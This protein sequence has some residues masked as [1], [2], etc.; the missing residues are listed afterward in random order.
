MYRYLLCFVLLVIQLETR[1]GKISGEVRSRQGDILPYS[2]LSVK[3]GTLSTSSNNQGQYFLELPA[4]TYTLVCRHVGYERLEKTVTVGAE[5]V[6]LDFILTPQTVSLQEVVVRPGDEDPAYAIIRNAI[7]RRKEYLNEFDA[8]QCEVYSK[9]VMNLRNYPTRFMGQDVD[10]EDGDTSK[11][12]MIYLSETVSLLSEEKPNKLKID[13]LSTRVSG[14]QDGFGFTGARFFS[15]YENNVQIS[16]ALNPRGFV[17]P[18]ADN[19]LQFYRYRYEGLFSE[20]GK[21]I[22]K[23]SVIPRRKYE[24]SFS[25]T[26]NIVEDEWRIHSLALQLTKENQMGFADTLRIE[27]LYTMLGVNQWVMQSQ[28]L[29]PSVKLLG[30]DA[31]G[32]FANVYRN[33]NV[34]PAYD[35][36]FFNNT[37][38][39]YQ[40]GSN[41][42]PVAYWDSIRP[43]ALTQEEFSDYIRKDSLEQLRSNPAYLDSID[44]IRNRVKPNQLLLTGKTFSISRKK[45]TVAVPSLLTAAG[46]NPVDGW[47]ADV[48][49]VITRTYTDRKNLTLTPHLR[50][51]FSSRDFYAWGTVRYNYGSRYLSGLTVSG[52]R[53]FFQ[54]DPSDPIEPVQ[55]TFSALFYKNNFMKFYQADYGRISYFTGIGKGITLSGTFQYQDRVP[56]DN[57]VDFSWS[58]KDRPYFP[59]FP[60]EL[61][62]TNFTRHQAALLTLQAT[63]RPGARYI[64]F[65]DRTVNIGSKWPVF[66]AQYTRGLTGLL[67]NDV[68]FDRWQVTV[69]DNL[70]AKLAGRFSYRIRTGG[71]LNSNRVEWQDLH[72][73]AGNRLFRSSDFMTTFQVPQYYR[74]SNAAPFFMA[75]FTEHHFNGFLTNKI[76]GIKQL[77]W[78]LVAGARALWYEKTAYWEW[79]VGLENIFRLF[80]VDVVTGYQNGRATVPEIRIGSRV[81]IGSSAD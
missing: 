6:R 16:N 26:I 4:G 22:N 30:F 23:I 48:P 39:R 68:D 14:Q 60:T 13:V 78:H 54:F 24:P 64:E 10:F 77:N 50:Y 58:N 79:N 61:G 74:F 7:K 46:F 75:L 8:F 34:R 70:N 20:E 2:T 65:P 47:V 37:I 49:V 9:G 38:I 52:G 69:R 29:F 31:Y 12:K 44:R 62:T 32:S 42:K 40:Q 11:R 41:R 28:V 45:L 51:G 3:G 63:F 81:N 53:R 18:I 43:L 27:Q 15:F 59:N 33:F 67:G 35:K 1:A 36:K 66:Q 17:S 19:A 73:F 71:F 21:L 80:R 25:G 76:P 55:N 5:S 72:H 57:N 56:L